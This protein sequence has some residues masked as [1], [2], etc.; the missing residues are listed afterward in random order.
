MQK[1][2]RRVRWWG[3]VSLGLTLVAAWVVSA[4]ERSTEVGPVTPAPPQATFVPMPIDETGEARDRAIFGEIRRAQ[5]LA[6]T[7]ARGTARQFGGAGSPMSPSSRKQ[8]ALSVTLAAELA[9]RS[10]Q[11]I[12]LAY[13]MS[14]GDLKALSLR[15]DAAGWS[16]P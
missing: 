16:P 14:V 2:M 12:A 3:V 15:G 5:N 7:E 10:L 13:E 11:Q 6:M 8:E 4:P 9:G 1:T